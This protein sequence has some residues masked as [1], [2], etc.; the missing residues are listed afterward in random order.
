VRDRAAELGRP[1]PLGIDMDEQL[2]LGDLGEG[3]DPRLIDF[4]PA[5]TEARSDHTGEFGGWNPLDVRPIAHSW[6]PNIAGGAVTPI[7][8]STGRIAPVV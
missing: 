6:A 5:R 3:V 2:V 7:P 8:P 1:R 4:E